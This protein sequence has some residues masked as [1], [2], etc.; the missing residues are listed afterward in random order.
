MAWTIKLALLATDLWEMKINSKNHIVMKPI[1]KLTKKCEALLGSNISSPKTSFLST[2]IRSRN[3]KKGYKIIGKSIKQ[4][5]RQFKIGK[6]WRSHKYK[7]ISQLVNLSI[8]MFLEWSIKWKKESS[9]Y[10][11]YAKEQGGRLL[12]SLHELNK[13]QTGNMVQQNS[14]IMP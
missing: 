10:F 12:S 2:K 7:L 1:G 5:L 13:K 9:R 8:K 14:E 6:W 11:Q 3:L 4:V